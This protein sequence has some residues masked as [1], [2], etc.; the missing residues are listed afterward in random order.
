MVE[1]TFST[2]NVSNKIR[3]QI[4]IVTF[5][6]LRMGEFSILIIKEIAGLVFKKPLQNQQ[7]FWQ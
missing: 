1:E 4:I 5:F 2:K 3:N 7:N 6:F